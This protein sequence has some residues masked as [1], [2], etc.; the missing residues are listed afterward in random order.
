MGRTP[1]KRG[2]EAGSASTSIVARS[3]GELKRRAL[4]QQLTM[5]DV[6]LVCEELE[7]G[8]LFALIEPHLY[9]APSPPFGR[10]ISS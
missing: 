7:V 9:Y 6:Q 8:V 2:S 1:S 10:L 5:R 4:R 3:E